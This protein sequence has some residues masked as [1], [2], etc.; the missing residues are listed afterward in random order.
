M[1]MRNPLVIEFTGTPN[2]GKTTLI[3]FLHDLLKSKGYH[4]EIKQEDAEIVPKCIPKKTWPR[5]VWITYGQL[6]SLIETKYSEAD[7]IL[8]DRGFYD[9]KFWAEFLKIQHV[10]TEEE[11]LSLLKHLEDADKQFHLKPNW[12][13]AIDVSTEVSLKRRYATI[14]TEPVTLTTNAFI[15]LYK[16]ELEKFYANVDVPLFKLDT[17]NLTLIEMQQLVL[18]KITDILSNYN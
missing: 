16:E 18:D 14:N 15:S 4:V 11:S 12:L 13:F 8:L 5:N 17:S 3:K 6:Q 2:S 7:V 1:N 10:C 9:S